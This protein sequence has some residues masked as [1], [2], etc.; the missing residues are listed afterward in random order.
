MRG[1][2]YSSKMWLSAI[3]LPPEAKPDTGFKCEWFHTVEKT[4]VSVQNP[5]FRA[6]PPGSG[7][8]GVCACQLLSVFG[9]RLLAGWADSGG[10]DGK[11][12]S[13]ATAQ[14]K[15][16]QWH[17]DSSQP[18][19]CSGEACEEQN[20]HCSRWKLLPKDIDSPSLGRKVTRKNKS[21]GIAKTQA[22]T[23]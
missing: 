18:S 5:H 15:C 19:P 9:W 17:G 12:P 22:S 1:L 13:L 14:S 23:L 7:G 3:G 6:L 8:A 11:F 10:G 16:R 20:G 4:Q 21:N 2:V